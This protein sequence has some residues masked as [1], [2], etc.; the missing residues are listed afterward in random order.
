MCVK[1]E[2]VLTLYDDES[3]HEKLTVMDKLDALNDDGR[4]PRMP[5]E[6]AVNNYLKLDHTYKFQ[7]KV[8]G[9]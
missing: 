2:E 1:I 7:L 5:Y 3:V 4:N 6:E 8:C 9:S